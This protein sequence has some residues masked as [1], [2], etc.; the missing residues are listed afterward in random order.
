MSLTRTLK[1]SG[2]LWRTLED[3]GGLW[4]TLEDSGG[5]WRTL[6]DSGAR[7]LR[8]SKF[9]WVLTGT[10]FNFLT[11]KTQLYIHQEQQTYI[12]QVGM[13]WTTWHS[14]LHCHPTT[15]SEI[16]M[17]QKSRNLGAID[18]SSI[19]CTKERVNCINRTGSSGPR[20]FPTQHVVC[21]LTFSYSRL[22]CKWSLFVIC[23]KTHK[24]LLPIT[25]ITL[26]YQ[27]YDN[28]LGVLPGP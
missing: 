14:W 2:G 7:T 16:W 19:F 25:V 8:F 24:M 28:F 20:M 18:F 6:E 5:L 26:K 11:S 17:R 22:R 27:F 12:F 3:S 4:R 10:G 9:N 1:Y 23:L 21:I 15:K 13:R